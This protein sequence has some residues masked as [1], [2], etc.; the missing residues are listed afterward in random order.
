MVEFGATWCIPCAAMI[1]KL[2]ALADKYPEM[3]EVAGIFVMEQA[4][5]Y[6][7]DGTPDYLNKVKKYVDRQVKIFGI[8]LLWTMW[9]DR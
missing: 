7:I 4:D 5:G 3:L 1:P 8:I 9:K 2:S 6:V